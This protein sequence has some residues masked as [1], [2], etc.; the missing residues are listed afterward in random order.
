[1][2]NRVYDLLGWHTELYVNS[3]SLKELLN[4]LVKLPLVSI[5]HLGLQKNGLKSL[6]KL[7]EKGIKVKATG[8][9]R[10]DFEVLPVLKEIHSIHEQSLM[11]GTDLPS[12][13][14]PTPYKLDDF[15]LVLDN[16]SKEDSEKILFNNAINFYKMGSHA[17]SVS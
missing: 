3:S 13:R 17:H 2:A 9:G 14:S 7:A 12:T 1:M 16:F 11:F 10:V 15:K 6:Y 5:D 4:L 8:F